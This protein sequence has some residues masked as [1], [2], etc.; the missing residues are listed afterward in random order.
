MDNEEKTTDEIKDTQPVNNG[1]GPKKPKRKNLLIIFAIVFCLI[2]ASAAYFVL[3]LNK[4]KKD[5][6]AD[7]FVAQFPSGET[8]SA[9]SSV[10]DSAAVA[11]QPANQNDAENSYW[12]VSDNPEYPELAGNFTVLPSAVSD[13]S[14][15]PL[16]S[17]PQGVAANSQFEITTG[18]VSMDELKSYL[19]VKSGETFTLTKQEK[20]SENTY[21]LSFDTTLKHNKIYNLIYSPP[22]KTPSSYAF[23]T[24]DTFRIVGTTPDTNT[25]GV[26]VNSGIEVVFSHEITGNFSD[27]FSVTPNVNG[28]FKQVGAR[29]IFVPEKLNYGTSYTA[30]IKPGITSENGDKLASGYDFTF[31][32]EWSD[33]S[34][35]QK[36][37]EISGKSHETFLPWDDVYAGIY[38]EDS[39]LSADY[40]VTVYDMKTPDNYINYDL[41]T[42]EIPR[43]A[44]VIEQLT[45]KLETQ[46]TGSYYE[47]HYILLGKPLPEG[48]YMLDIRT[49]QPSGEEYSA[50]KMIQV[51]PVSVYSLSID[52]E[53]CYWVNDAVTGMPAPGAKI[54]SGSLNAVTG[55]DGTAIIKTALYEDVVTKIDYADYGTFVYTNTTYTP[56]ELSA[57]GKYLAYM[58]TDRDF[59]RENDTIDIF[60]VI[61]AK[62]GYALTESDT[63]TLKLGDMREVS[64]KPD[65]YGVYSLKLPVSGMYGYVPLEIYINE[66]LLLSK[67][68][69]FT[70][71][72]NDSYVLSSETNRLAYF[73]GEEAQFLLTA[74]T[75]DKSPVEGLKLSSSYFGEMSVVTDS[76]G[77]AQAK[78]NISPGHSYQNWRPSWESVYFY[79]ASDSES[80]Q[81]VY[82]PVVIIPSDTMLTYEKITD[83]SFEF[84]A[85]K[86]DRE[87]LEQHYKGAPVYSH[88]DEQ[89]FT[90]EATDIEFIVD[91]EKNE[92]VKTL[93]GESYD[94]I[95]KR[96]ISYYDYDTVTTP[97]DMYSVR[98]RNGKAVL[99]NLPESTDPLI[100]YSVKIL[101]TDSKGYPITLNL[102]YGN[103][104]IYYGD[105]SGIRNYYLTYGE[106][107]RGFSVGDRVNLRLADFNSQTGGEITDG[108]LL[109]ILTRDNII[110]AAVGS[111]SETPV[112]FTQDCISDANV[113][114]AYFDGKYIYPISYPVSLSYNPEDMKLNFDISFD[115]ESYKPGDEVNAE[116]K[117]TDN[118]GIA[119]KAEITVSVVDES[120]F[121]GQAHE[122]NLLE[123]LYGSSYSYSSYAS[124]WRRYTVYSS[125]IQSGINSDASNAGAEMGGGGENTT[126]RKDFTDNPAFLTVETNDSGTASLNFKLSD[127]VT[128]WRVTALGITADGFAGSEKENITATLPFYVSM[129]MSPEFLTGDEIG[130]FV[131][132]YGSEYKY[133]DQ[134]GS[135]TLEVFKGNETVFTETKETPVYAEFNAG[136]LESGE[137]TVR[138]SAER[139]GN[140]DAMEKPLR[141][142]E[143][144]H[145]IPLTSEQTL[146]EISQAP[147]KIDVLDLPVKVTL[148]NGDIR[149]VMRILASCIQGDTYRTDY[150]AA[151][152]Y[153]TYFYSSMLDFDE[154][155][156]D[157]AS[158]L[159]AT[160]RDMYGIPQITY[161]A[162]DYFYTARFAASFPEFV[163]AEYIANYIYYEGGL[164]ANSKPGLV[165]PPADDEAEL[166]RAAGYLALAA[167]GKPVLLEIKDQ[168]ELIRNSDNKE[169]FTNTHNGNMR[170]LYY[171]AAL[172]ALG[173]T[174]SANNLITEF[175]PMP[176]SARMAQ[177]V[178]T[179]RR[180]EIDTLA[181]YIYTATNPGLAFE[182]LKTKG[183]NKYVS[184]VS[185]KIN[186]LKKVSLNS[187]TVSEVVYTLNGESKT[188]QLKNFGRVT[189]D[190]SK[191]QFESLNLTNLSG[192][193]DI[194]IGYYSDGT[195][196]SPGKGNISFTKEIT[197]S[198]GN[199]SVTFKG[200]MPQLTTAGYYTI[201][202]RLPS[203]MRYL[204]VRN[205]NYSSF[206]SNPEGQ[207]VNI[208][209]YF[210]PEKGRNFSVSYSAMKVSNFNA[211][212]GKA[213]IVRRYSDDSVWGVSE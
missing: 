84:S 79:S 29:Y 3:Y 149:P 43:D 77:T 96:N 172:S 173:D 165:T 191:E 97:Y 157:Y 110:E 19:S 39:L 146:S 128:S 114:G 69:T 139:S 14:I 144:A 46:Q 151:R 1:N 32:T 24:E 204:P 199:Y 48:W 188:E 115:K 22:E 159:K 182:Y 145:K 8:D 113:F 83:N 156:E 53:I 31:N 141:V 49:K 133:N 209:F 121:L 71:Y 186:F 33:S 76:T 91:I 86:I 63:V 70:N 26:P 74:E 162:A 45:T 81:S 124:G 80:S 89:Y 44:E 11:E 59:Y 107:Y 75:F 90:G 87:K 125:Y 50:K 73:L 72:T 198:G 135:Y 10:P 30:S 164:Y 178:D 202:D 94:F 111:P 171:A 57:S 101:Y 102:G 177:N 55:T 116:I 47:S 64:L 52:G 16:N 176:K 2:A 4:N 163:N 67:H 194:N 154:T 196:L 40:S 20:D 169:I 203:N 99:D 166:K 123:N 131:K 112:T 168:V 62:E 105:D 51:S 190:I 187:M 58:Y 78:T 56:K 61:R 18:G 210:D 200:T 41:T 174:Y 106:D 82:S 13:I 127:A 117:V 170:V 104:N 27:Y 36:G 185:E 192:T 25:Y 205:E 28:E 85:N 148:T 130:V 7:G 153:A 66:S 181:L 100:Y 93:R 142:T 9:A 120:S 109:A 208:S 68:V 35:S 211:V 60:G 126:L 88:L 179:V 119:K 54:T 150:M 147:E 137:Y 213:Y 184:D 152:E 6:P 201:F 212:E 122:A 5:T 161:E 155:D 21:L 42:G 38:A 143:S 136:Q 206:A 167:L 160:L 37:I 17:T 193:T 207:L 95:S 195:S 12:E 92:I 129:V 34:S 158:E 189:L 23:Q 103:N 15:I 108:R 132:S 180:E 98:T 140:T 118:E 138:V 175:K 65:S 197:E 183:E 134:P